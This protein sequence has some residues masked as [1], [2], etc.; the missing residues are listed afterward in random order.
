MSSYLIHTINYGDNQMRTRS[1]SSKLKNQRILYQLI[2]GTFKKSIHP[3]FGQNYFRSYQYTQYI[4]CLLSK[5]GRKSL[6]SKN[7]HYVPEMQRLLA[8]LAFANRGGL[9]LHRVVFNFLETPFYDLFSSKRKY[10][11]TVRYFKTTGQLGRN[12]M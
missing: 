9:F 5:L 3:F 4:L 8:H 7:W 10:P 11:R 2:I 12:S 1:F 6:I